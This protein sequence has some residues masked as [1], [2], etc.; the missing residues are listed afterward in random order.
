MCQL[1]VPF[2]DIKTSGPCLVFGRQCGSRPTSLAL[3]PACGPGL[4]TTGPPR[5]RRLL[6]KRRPGEMFHLEGSIPPER[7]YSICLA[8]PGWSGRAADKGWVRANA[9]L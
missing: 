2:Y 7:E 4:G 6:S 3:A 1:G 8:L 5:V 9:V